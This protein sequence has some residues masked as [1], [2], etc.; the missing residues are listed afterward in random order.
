MPYDRGGSVVLPSLAAT[1]AALDAALDLDQAATTEAPIA[2][3]VRCKGRVLGLLYTVAEAIEC[4]TTAGVLAFHIN[5]V[6]VMTMAVVDATAVDT[7]VMILGTLASGQNGEFKAGDVLKLE[8]KTQ[9]VDAGA[10]TGQ[11]VPMPVVAIDQGP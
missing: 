3:T 10:T 7:M 6:E 5:D 9:L 11:I 4:S 1:G 2:L 8:I